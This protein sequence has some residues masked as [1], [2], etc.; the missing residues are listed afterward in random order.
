MGEGIIALQGAF[1]VLR[2]ASKKGETMVRSSCLQNQ[3]F[4]KNIWFSRSRVSCNLCYFFVSLRPS[5][6]WVRWQ[7]FGFTQEE[8][9]M[10]VVP[11]GRFT[12][13]LLINYWIY[14]TD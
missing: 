6:L 11:T 7:G 1:N 14:L 8:A 13:L 10:F 12:D 9:A 4:V 5:V 2:I 3:A